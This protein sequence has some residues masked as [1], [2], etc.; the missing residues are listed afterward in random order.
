MRSASSLVAV[1]VALALSAG[2]AV[3]ATQQEEDS[4]YQ[5]GRWAVLSP[6]A[7]A[8]EP[9]V[10]PLTPDAAYN[11]RPEEFG[12]EVDLLSSG[13]QPPTPPEPPVVVPNP[14]DNPPP[15]GDPRTPPPVVVPN[16]GTQPPVG[17]PRTPRVVAN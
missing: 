6:A 11:L 3:A 2:Q 12:P 7:G 8:G 15:V 1:G 16:P 13:P 14:P 10:A 17:D 4:V 9:Y 5:Y